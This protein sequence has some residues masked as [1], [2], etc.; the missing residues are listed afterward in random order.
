MLCTAIFTAPLHLA[1][2]CVCCLCEIMSQ[3]A[4]HF[5]PSRQSFL[6]KVAGKDDPEALAAMRS[7]IEDFSPLLA[8]VHTF[9]VREAGAGV[10]GAEAVGDKQCWCCMLLSAVGQ[11]IWSHSHERCCRCVDSCRNVLAVSCFCLLAWHCLL[12]VEYDN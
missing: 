7:F 8:E 2:L 1:G 6:E 11:A 3:V 9:L 5:I 12:H 10:G 4:F